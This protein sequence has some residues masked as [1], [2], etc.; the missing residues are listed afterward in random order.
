[1]PSVSAAVFRGGE[2]MWQEALGVARVE[3]AEG[4]TPAHQYRVGSITKTFTAVSSCS[5]ATRDGWSSR[6][7]SVRSSPRRRTA[8]P[9]ATRSR[10]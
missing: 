6:R 4:T 7:T 10:T 2:L 1:M 8:R 3:T 5:C 9:S